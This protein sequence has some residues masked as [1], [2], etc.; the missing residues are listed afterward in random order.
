MLLRDVV[1]F[2]RNDLT[3]TAST[4]PHGFLLDPRISGRQMGQLQIATFFASAG[5]TII[6][7]DGPGPVWETPIADPNELET[8]HY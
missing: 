7:P 2:Y 8:T 6:D 4:N 1:S 3:P 5:T